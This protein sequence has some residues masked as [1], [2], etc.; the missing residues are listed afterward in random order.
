MAFTRV[1]MRLVLY[2]L[3]DDAPSRRVLGFVARWAWWRLRPQVSLEMI[4][5]EVG[6]DEE[7]MTSRL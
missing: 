6:I 2:R 4:A 1:E 5:G 7:R 3:T